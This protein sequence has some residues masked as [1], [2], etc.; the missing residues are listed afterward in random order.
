MA[1]SLTLTAENLALLMT[2]GHPLYIVKA[3]DAATWDYQRPITVAEI[4][5]LRFKRQ[6]F[7]VGNR[8][9]KEA[10]ELE[11]AAGSPPTRAQLIGKTLQQF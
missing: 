3:V 11:L 8:G 5:G 2:A 6:L 1:R 10:I 9:H 4:P 7:M